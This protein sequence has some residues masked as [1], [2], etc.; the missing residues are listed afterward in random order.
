M[1]LLDSSTLTLCRPTITEICGMVV[2]HILEST[3]LTAVS[4]CRV[5]R[6]SRGFF[7]LQQLGSCEEHGPGVSELKLVG[8]TLGLSP[9]GGGFLTKKFPEI[10]TKS[11]VEQGT[12]ILIMVGKTCLAFTVKKYDGKLNI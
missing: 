2:G 4:S 8:G 3:A 10:G 7:Q 12:C 11:Y 1:Q 5:L 6:R 9:Q